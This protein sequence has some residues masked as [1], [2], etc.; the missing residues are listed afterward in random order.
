MFK[1]STITTIFLIFIAFTNCTPNETK[2]LLKD[3]ENLTRTILRLKQQNEEHVE[4]NSI[5][6]KTNIEQ[7]MALATLQQKQD[8]L[9]QD[10]SRLS[11]D[12]RKKNE[13]LERLKQNSSSSRAIFESKSASNK[14]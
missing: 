2:S 7:T 13:E 6:T 1:F 11:E 3:K 9:Q 5:L 12:F 8:A 10:Y 14:H 4:E